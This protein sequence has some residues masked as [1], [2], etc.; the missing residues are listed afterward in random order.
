[1]GRYRV[2]NSA[3]AIYRQQPYMSCVIAGSRRP[4]GSTVTTIIRPMRRYEGITYRSS[5]SNRIGTYLLARRAG[6]VIE[7]R[8]CQAGQGTTMYSHITAPFFSQSKQF[9]DRSVD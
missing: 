6:F 7:R 1:M 9:R 2:N 5:V 8:V 3:G 4:H